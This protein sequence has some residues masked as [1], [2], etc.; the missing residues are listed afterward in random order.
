MIGIHRYHNGV[1][2]IMLDWKYFAAHLP[3]NSKGFKFSDSM[4]SFMRL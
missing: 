3:L 4:I 2:I 1:C